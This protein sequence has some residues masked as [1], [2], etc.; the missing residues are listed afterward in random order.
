VSELRPPSRESPSLVTPMGRVVT[1]VGASRHQKWR[2]SSPKWRD[3]APKLQTSSQTR[4][5]RGA[6][7]SP[8]ARNT[9]REAI[10]QDTPN[11]QRGLHAG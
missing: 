10:S 1:K 3:S 4:P 7:L 5:K 9:I 8:C 2:D 11:G 6:R